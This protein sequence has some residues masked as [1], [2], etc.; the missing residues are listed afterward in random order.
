M[1]VQIAFCPSHPLTCLAAS[2]AHAAVIETKF[3][4][5]VAGDAL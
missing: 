4:Q 3:L 1:Y 5:R 2:D